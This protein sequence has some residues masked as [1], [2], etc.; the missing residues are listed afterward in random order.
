MDII[1][2]WSQHPEIVAIGQSN[3]DK[4]VNVLARTSF[5]MEPLPEI[6][7]G[8]KIELRIEAPRSEP[9]PPPKP[10]EQPSETINFEELSF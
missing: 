5:E 2:W 7:N 9:Q 10:S 6:W 1:Q 8:F 3:I 4:Q